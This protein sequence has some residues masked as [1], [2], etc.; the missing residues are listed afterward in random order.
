MIYNKSNRTNKQTTSGLSNFFKGTVPGNKKNCRS[1][2]FNLFEAASKFY[3]AV[4]GSFYSN[5]MK[6]KNCFAIILAGVIV[7]KAGHGKIK[8]GE[9]SMFSEDFYSACADEVMKKSSL[10][11]D[12]ELVIIYLKQ[13]VHMLE[14][15]GILFKDNDDIINV[16]NGLSNE[17]VYRNLF[18]SFWNSVDWKT[19]FPSSPESADA[20]YKNRESFAGLLCG[21]Y[22]FVNIE[23][24]A[25]DFFNLTEITS[26]NDSFMIS[27]IDFYLLTWLNNFGIIEY[28]TDSAD[29]TVYVSLTDSGRPFLESL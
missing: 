21:Y 25:N 9:N 15:C 10:V 24:L 2:H 11:D 29:E 7:E 23:T 16:E 20:L 27:F 18:N 22:G 28:H 8:S 12:R 4:P 6:L 26:H 3:S 5:P 19:I 13:S 1:D 17:R 14:N